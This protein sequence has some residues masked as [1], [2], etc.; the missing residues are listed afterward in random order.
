MTS[1]ILLGK[2][3]TSTPANDPTKDQAII[4]LQQCITTWVWKHSVFGLH[5]DERYDY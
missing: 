3:R 5:D 2:K 4:T 1:F